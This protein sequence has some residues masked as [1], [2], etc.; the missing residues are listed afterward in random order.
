MGQLYGGG[1]ICI[2]ADLTPYAASI[3][4][5]SSGTDNSTSR[6]HGSTAGGTTKYAVALGQ[7]QEGYTSGIKGGLTLSSTRKLTIRGSGA[8]TGSG[9]NSMIILRLTV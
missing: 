1:E 3:F 5:N 7:Y 4:N 6:Y 8:H 9:E 2:V